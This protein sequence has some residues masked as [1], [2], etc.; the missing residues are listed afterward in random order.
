MQM[1]SA[2]MSFLRRVVL[3]TFL[4]A[5]VLLFMAA[6]WASGQVVLLLLLSMLLALFLREL[7]RR[8]RRT[9]PVSPAVSVL[10]VTFTLLCLGGMT[11][12]LLAPEI[13]AQAEGLVS[14]VPESWAQIQQRWGHHPVGKWI[15]RGVQAEAPDAPVR[16][17]MSRAT[18]IFSSVLGAG[19]GLLFVFFMSLYLALDPHRYKNGVLVLFPAPRRSR[20]EEIMDTTAERL[21]QFLVAQGASMLVVFVMTTVGLWMIGMPVYLA[22]GLLSGLLTFIPYLGPLLSFLPAL[23]VAAA[24]NGTSVLSVTL[25]Y[26]TVQLLESYLITPMMQRKIADL[27][28]ALTIL[29]QGALGLYS[30]VLGVLLAAPLTAA[31]M[32]IVKMAYLEDVLQEELDPLESTTSQS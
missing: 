16:E 28:P 9:L 10:I 18:G 11:L 23:L 12:W 31:G 8:L 20:V 24:S 25:L 21:W 1:L 15:L 5:M 19:S 30:G 32:V 3:G 26:G 27:P 4:A 29:V 7:S 6:V 22:L 2:D 17:L 14:Q 13:T